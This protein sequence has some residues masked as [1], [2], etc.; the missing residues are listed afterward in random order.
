[1]VYRHQTHSVL[2]LALVLSACAYPRVVR[3]FDEECQV[4]TKHVVLDV[5]DSHGLENCLKSA[6]LDCRPELVGL[7][8]V[9][10]TSTIIS[11]SIAIVG[12]LVY[13]AERKANCRPLNASLP[14]SKATN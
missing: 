10:A 14:P 1:M 7:G 11:G 12:N 3:E 4:M 8:V 9:L 5:K 13:W 2:A 6:R